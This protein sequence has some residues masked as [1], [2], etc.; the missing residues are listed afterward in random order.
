MFFVTLWMP[1][2]SF[3][4]LSPDV[5]LCGWLGSKYQLTKFH[6]HIDKPHWACT[7]SMPVSVTLA[8]FQG[9]KGMTQLRFPV[10]FIGTQLRFPVK[11][12]GTLWSNQVLTSYGCY[13]HGHSYSLNAYM[14][15]VCTWGWLL[16]HFHFA[17]EQFFVRVCLAKVKWRCS[18]KIS[19]NLSPYSY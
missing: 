19:A 1:D 15:L 13:I 8:R 11:F 7:V 16:M 9:H 14:T 5:I 17:A 10:K 18:I 4:V 3:H 2:L 6:V 12:I